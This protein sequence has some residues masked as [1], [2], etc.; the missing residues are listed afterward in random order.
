MKT[1]VLTVRLTPEA[2]KAFSDLAW[3]QRTSMNKLATEL[4][5]EAIVLHSRIKKAGKVGAK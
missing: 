3:E 4:I 2:H 5:N 1:N